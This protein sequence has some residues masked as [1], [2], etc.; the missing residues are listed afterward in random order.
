MTPE[1]RILNLVGLAYRARKTVCGDFAAEKYLKRQTVP[2]LLL[3]C[4]SGADNGKKYRQLAERLHIHI[5]D[6]LTKEQLG[7]AVG[8]GRHVVVLITDTGLAKAIENVVC[9]KKDDEGG[10]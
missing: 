5:I 8:K 1:Q 7:E 2:L 4:D 10:N 9:T 3:A 6:T